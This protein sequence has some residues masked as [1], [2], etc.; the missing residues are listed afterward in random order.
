MRIKYKYIADMGYEGKTIAEIEAELGAQAE[1]MATTMQQG[2]T[3]RLADVTASLADLV[4]S[5]ACRH[6]WCWLRFLSPEKI[7]LNKLQVGHA[8]DPVPLQKGQSA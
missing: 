1:G 7:R 5:S 6:P 2:T 3:P 8:A 4:S